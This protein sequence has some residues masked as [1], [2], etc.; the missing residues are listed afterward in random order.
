MTEVSVKA[1][2]CH[3]IHALIISSALPNS[4]TLL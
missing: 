2:R 3:F 4:T 1:M